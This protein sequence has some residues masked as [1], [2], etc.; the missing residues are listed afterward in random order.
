VGGGGRVYNLLCGPHVGGH[1]GVEI[2]EAV[3]YRKGEA[4]NEPAKATEHSPEEN[5]ILLFTAWY[6]F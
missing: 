6:F 1:V 2:A 3:D 4:D 5:M